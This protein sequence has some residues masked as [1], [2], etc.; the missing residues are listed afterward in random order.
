M[1]RDWAVSCCQT[2]RSSTSSFVTEA[3][4][5]ILSD[6]AGCAG[7]VTALPGSFYA[8]EIMSEAL[9]FIPRPS[10]SSL[11]LVLSRRMVKV[12][13]GCKAQRPAGPRKYADNPPLAFAVPGRQPP[14]LPAHA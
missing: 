1:V 14:R 6:H 3:P 7:I 12:R 4:L 5:T 11:V 10:G 9:A 13:I 2:H 8:W